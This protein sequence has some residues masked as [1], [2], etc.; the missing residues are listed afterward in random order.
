M[1]WTD[2]ETT[3]ILKALAVACELTGT[4]YS[5]PAR[6]LILEELQAYPAGRV[7]TALRQCLKSCNGKLTLGAVVRQMEH[8]D[9]KALSD[10]RASRDA[11]LTHLRG[12]ALIE[13]IAWSPSDPE[14]VRRALEAK[15]YRFAS[16]PEKPKALMPH[17]SEQD[18]E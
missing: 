17:W 12:C 11:Y 10:Q 14:S 8:V 15:G 2:E 16:T 9:R 7:S 4:T 3:E 6:K 1:A 13:R 5:E 18:R